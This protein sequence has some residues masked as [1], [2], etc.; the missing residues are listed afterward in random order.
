MASTTADQA[1]RVPDEADLPDI[2]L[3]LGRSVADIEKKLFRV[4]NS[5][6]DRNTKNTSPTEGQVAY[7]KDVDQMHFYSGSAWV[8]FYPPVVPAFSS[9]TTVPSNGSGANGDVFFKL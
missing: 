4:Y 1:L 9:G 3:V 6:T 8:Q 2:P 7:L 5:A